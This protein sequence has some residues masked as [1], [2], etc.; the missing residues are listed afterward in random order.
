MAALLTTIQSDNAARGSLQR[1]TAQLAN[2][3]AALELNCPLTAAGSTTATVTSQVKT[4]NTLT[5]LI[6]GERGARRYDSEEMDLEGDLGKF[7]YLTAVLAPP[8]MAIG[9][10]SKALSKIELSD[11][12]EDGGGKSIFKLDKVQ[13]K[14]QIAASYDYFYQKV[15]GSRG[16]VGSAINLT[17]Q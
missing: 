7:K 5:F 16:A 2:L 14:S 3:M 8:G 11:Q 6:A 9:W 4:A 1:N 10:Y 15:C 17:E 13:G 12:P